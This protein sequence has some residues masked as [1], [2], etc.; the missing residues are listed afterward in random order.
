MEIP[1]L[2]QHCRV[3]CIRER[4]RV[5]GGSPS[6]DTSRRHTALYTR[7]KQGLLGHPSPARNSGQLSQLVPLIVTVDALA[8]LYAAQTGQDPAIPRT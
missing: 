7:G 2:L 6:L 8:F 5:Q 1:E 3:R 4:L